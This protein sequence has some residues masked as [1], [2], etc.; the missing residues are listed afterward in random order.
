[1]PTSRSI[2]ARAAGGPDVLV[3]EQRET[4]APGP[5]QVAVEVSVSGVNPV[6]AK[7][8]GGA[9]GPGLFPYVPGCELAGRVVEVGEGV[10]AFAVGDRVAALALPF[11]GDPGS[12][13]DRV[14]VA[15]D[16]LAAVPAG[17]SDETVGANVLL[18][19][20]ALR[21]LRVAELGSG[22]RAIVPGAAGGVGRW[23]V[24]LLVRDGVQ[25]TT[26]TSSADVP[27]MTALGAHAVSRD[28]EVAL[29]GLG[30]FDVVF[31][32]AGEP[33]AD[34]PAPGLGHLAGT[35]PQRHRQGRRHR[36]GPSAVG[37]GRTWGF[38]AGVADGT[39]SVIPAQLYAPEDVAPA[40]SDYLSR[41][42]AR[43]AL[44]FRRGR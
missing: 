30:G 24:Q 17:L 28:D 3:I 31:D 37:C 18:P 14:V 5:G 40:L 22:A 1:M 6:D 23:L 21:L 15:A 20:T 10:A 13:Q 25:V 11:A 33:G 9:F 7:V 44:D 16:R 19:L 29:A 43:T 12:W 32:V 4:V 26:V 8:V 42:H 27:A 41:A 38:L 34:R 2:V 39:F 35:L 36:D